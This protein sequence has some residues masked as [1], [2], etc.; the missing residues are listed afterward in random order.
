M[1]RPAS[2][3]ALKGRFREKACENVIL[4]SSEHGEHIGTASG[5][6]RKLRQWTPVV[7]HVLPGPH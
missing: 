2:G 5:H 6:A 4:H 1:A 3:P 7:L